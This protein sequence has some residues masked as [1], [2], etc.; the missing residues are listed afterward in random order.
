MEY[1]YFTIEDVEMLKFNGITHLHNHLNYLIH[2]DKDQK[3][4]N[5]DSVRNVSFIFDNKGNPKA[6][7]WTDDLGKRIELKKYVFRY[8]RDLYK[9]IVEFCNLMESV[10]LKHMIDARILILEDVTSLGSLYISQDKTRQLLNEYLKPYRF[11]ISKDYT[12]LHNIGNNHKYDV[13]DC[14]VLDNVETHIWHLSINNLMGYNSVM[15]IEDMDEKRIGSKTFELTKQGLLT[16]ENERWIGWDKYIQEKHLDWNL[17]DL[18][19]EQE[20]RSLVR[21]CIEEEILQVENGY[22][23]VIRETTDG[24]TVWTLATYE[25][26]IEDLKNE[27]QFQVF[28]DALQQKQQLKEKQESQS[29]KQVYQQSLKDMQEVYDKIEKFNKE[30]KAPLGTEKYEYELYAYMKQNGLYVHLYE[31]YENGEFLKDFDYGLVT[32]TIYGYPDKELRLSESFEIWGK[33][34]EYFGA[35]SK[36]DVMTK[37]DGLDAE[38]QEK[39]QSIDEE[40]DLELDEFE[41]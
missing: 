25:Q 21:Q 20:I 28:K 3:F 27:K 30:H 6:L 29:K 19:K 31:E 15:F 7:K 2:T 34:G 23:M 32:G 16:R 39:T 35:Y 41:K 4:T 26:V 24:N 38:Q 12:S 22:I 17:N 36:K 1:H 5:E 14:D 13:I 40:K 10:K 37:L 9:R 11:E 33:D 18:E 8:I